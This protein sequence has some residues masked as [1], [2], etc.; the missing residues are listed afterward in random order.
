[1]WIPVMAD[2]YTPGEIAAALQEGTG[3]SKWDIDTPALCVD[4]DKLEQ[5]ITRMQASVKTFGLATRPHAKTHK[6]AA[7][8]TMQ[9]AAGAIGICAAKL[10]EAE[11]LAAQ[12][13]DRLCLTTS[14]VSPAKIRRAMRLCARLPSFIQAVDAAPNARDLSEAAREAGV[15]ADV[16][17]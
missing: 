14:N 8:A 5:N 2:G 17:V 4:L 13:V 1:M 15:T 11:A 3:I 6:S 12:G 10:S 7:I 16:V 9:L